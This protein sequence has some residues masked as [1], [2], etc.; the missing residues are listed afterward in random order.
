MKRKICVITGSRAEYGLLKPLLMKLKT[1]RSFELQLVV[2]GMHLSPE[3]GYTVQ[4]IFNDNFKISEQIEMLLSTD[5]SAG[6]GKSIGVGIIGFVDCYKRLQPDLILVV[7]DR[8]EIFAAVIAASAMNIPIVHFSGGD[9]TEGSIDNQIRH[10]ITKLSHIHFVGITTSAQRVKQMGEEPWR[11]HV[12][13]EFCLDNIKSH[14]K[15]SRSKIEKELGLDLSIRPLILVTY[16]PVTLRPEQTR[17]QI[18]NLLEVLGLYKDS[19]IIFTYPNAD[20]GGRLII[21][22]IN[23]FLSAHPNAKAFKSVG[24][25]LYLNLLSC[26]DLCVGNSSSGLVE[27]PS[28]KLPVV[29]IGD[30][31]KGRLLP[32]NVI[33]TNGEK[34]SIHE[35]IKKG[36]SI[37]FKK[38]LVGMKNPYDKGGA[39]KNVLKVLHNLKTTPELLNKK[40]IEA[41]NK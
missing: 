14:Y 36:L 25:K 4:D 3:F 17:I 18:K 10:A 38:S 20:S 29:N 21:S 32:K 5:S 23:K 8:F 6:M 34:Q 11:V 9:I 24:T 37:G 22:E 40:F 31:Q 19:A 26:A 16:H 27:A 33:C 30:R 1:D 28:F 7:G 41:G 13:G 15:M 2:T 12:V 39:L 35:G